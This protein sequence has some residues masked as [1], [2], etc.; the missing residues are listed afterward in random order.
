MKYTVAFSVLAL[1]LFSMAIVQGSAY[2]LALWPGSSFL[3]LAVAYARLGPGVL[4]KR[5]DG[6]LAWWAVALLLPY[7]LLTWGLWHLLRMVQREKCC[8]EIVPGIWLGRRALAHELPENVDLVV[9]LTAEFFEERRV[10][11]RRTYWCLPTLDA[12]VPDDEPFQ[13]LVDKIV[14]WPGNAYI[15]CASGH[16]RSATVVAAVL[17][18]K[19]L[20]KNVD[21]A[22]RRIKTLRPGVGLEKQQWLLVDRSSRKWNPTAGGSAL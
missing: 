13:Q 10:V 9:D 1:C 22:V 7:L 16:G 17:I 20:A 14:A 2:W 5:A 18:R 3:V 4:G 8:Q 15:H 11:E 19:G 21:E 12:S 6:T